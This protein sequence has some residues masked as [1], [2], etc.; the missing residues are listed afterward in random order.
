MNIVSLYK[1]GELVEY[2]FTFDGLVSRK[3]W[4]LMRGAAFDAVK[5]F[6][7]TGGVHH[8]ADDISIGYHADGNIMYKSGTNFKPKKHIPFSKLN[9]PELF[10]RI[11]GFTL[12]ELKPKLP[13]PK[14][15]EAL[16]SLKNFSSH[17]RIACSIYIGKGQREINFQPT[18]K[19]HF[20][21]SESVSLYDS[22]NNIS[23]YLHLYE[24]MHTGSYVIMIL[25][26][27]TIFRKMVRFIR[28]YCYEFFDYLR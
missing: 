7:K 2:K 21:N 27:Y 22:E 17:T 6:R 10:L 28:Y 16:L 14:S 18:D 9:K 8:L 24:T 26:S 1:D 13:E 15:N 25:D 4:K 19:N 20:K 12:S 11:V 3:D 5:G 23:F